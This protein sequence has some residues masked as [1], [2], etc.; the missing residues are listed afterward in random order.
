MGVACRGAGA[1]AWIIRGWLL[2]VGAGR[3]FV[4]G[5]WTCCGWP[6]P[7]PFQPVWVPVRG[8]VGEVAACC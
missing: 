7:P 1:E 6:R 2:D 8:A 5:A 3:V 4:C